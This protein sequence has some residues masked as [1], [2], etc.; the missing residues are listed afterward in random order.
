MEPNSSLRYACT[1]CDGTGMEQPEKEECKIC[2]EEVEV[3]EDCAYCEE[4]DEEIHL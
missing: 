4:H 3:D 2:G 1:D